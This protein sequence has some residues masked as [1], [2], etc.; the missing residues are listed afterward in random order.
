MVVGGAGGLGIEIVK[1]HLEQGDRVWA[2]DLNESTL[3]SELKKTKSD[4][5][6]YFFPCDISSTDQVNAAAKIIVNSIDAV[7]R[8]YSCAGV[9]RVQDRVPLGETNL[10]AIPLIV[11]INA[12]G[13]LRI[14]KGLLP[15]IKNNCAIVC[16]TSEAASITNNHRSQEYSYGMSKCAE[17][18]ACVILQRYFTENVPGARVVCLH[19]GWLKT[20][21]G[22]GEIAEVE[23]ADSAA[24][25][26][27][28]AEEINQI[29]K[30]KMFID[31]QRNEIPW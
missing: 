11:D 20:Q 13:F 22:G 4:Q 23:P 21:M 2:I 16:V 24:A 25:L 31:Y 10:D 7:D 17:N 12:V 26:I 29:P 28:I 27:Q 19:P 18:M 14:I 15:V 8:I 1:Q 6:L 3:M 5:E 9:C 30:D